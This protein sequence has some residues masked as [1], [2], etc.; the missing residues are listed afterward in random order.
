MSLKL[1]CFLH[2]RATYFYSE[3]SSG[4]SYYRRALPERLI[5]LDSLDGTKH[6][7]KESRYS[8]RH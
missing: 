2:R 5:T 8:N 7:T 3:G 1:R 6:F 4:Q